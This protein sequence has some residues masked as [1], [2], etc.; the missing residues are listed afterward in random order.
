LSEIKIFE[1]GVATDQLRHP[2][3]TFYHFTKLVAIIDYNLC[4]PQLLSLS[5]FPCCT[6]LQDETDPCPG[7]CSMH[8]IVLNRNIPQ[9]LENVDPPDD[10]VEYVP[11]Y[12]S[13]SALASVLPPVLDAFLLRPFSEHVQ[14]CEGLEFVRATEVNITSI[15]VV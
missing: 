11:Q 14:V 3:Q 5:M 4:E 1:N 2:C 12:H 15:F 9:L 8:R 6:N 13:L 10:L 7:K